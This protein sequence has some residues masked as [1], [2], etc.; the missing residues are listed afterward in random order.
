M[1]RKRFHFPLGK[2]GIIGGG[3]LGKMMAQQA[4]R[5][6]FHI[7]VLD[8][9]PNCPAAQT[10]DEHILGDFFDENKLTELVEK[11]DVTTYDIEHV[12]TAVLQKL[13]DAGHDIHPSPHLLEIL[14]DKLRQ[15]E[16]LREHHVPVA[17]FQQ[18]DPPDFP[19]NLQFPL[20]QKVRH[21]GYDGR[22]VM[23]LR[24]R[25][26]LANAIPAPSMIETFVDFKKELAVMVARSA[27]GEIKCH[28]VVEMVFNDEANIC[29]MVIAPA[30]IPQHCAERARNVARHSIE[31]IDGVGI[32]G[33]EMFLTQDDDVLV[34]E[35]AARPHNSGHY[36]IEACSTCQ[37]EQHIRA[38]AGLPLGATNLLSPA[39][40]V[41]L[42]GCCN[43]EGPPVIEGL[44]EAL[45]LP[46]LSF[47]F[48]GKKVSLPFRKMGHVTIVD[49]AVEDAIAKAAKA[50][51]LVT[52]TGADRSL[53]KSRVQM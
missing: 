49:T 31:A 30:R 9:T 20:V 24:D 40:M 26:A 38:V 17:A 12:N 33:V 2:I 7:A 44:H 6:G 35:I 22:G 43:S 47:H 32:F 52:V 14:Q 1:Y 11:S 36:T 51:K 48:Y 13:A 45:S 37:F 10:A 29:D 25:R 5:M 53:K 3:Q 28:P 42:L 27:D 34:N 41:N 23:V 8:P 19:A 46:G 4:K 15:K 21:G 50:K 18:A 16:V 39:V